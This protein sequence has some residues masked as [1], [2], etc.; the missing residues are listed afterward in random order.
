MKHFGEANCVGGLHT[1]IG[2]EGNINVDDK[3]FVEFRTDKATVLTV[4][5]GPK[6]YLLEI[7]DASQIILSSDDLP[8]NNYHKK[9]NELGQGDKQFLA[10]CS[11]EQLPQHVCHL[12]RQLIRSIRDYSDDVLIEGK[13]R[14]WY[15]KPKNFVAVTIQNKKMRLCIQVKD[16]PVL[17]QLKNVEVYRDKR[18][19]RLF[20][21]QPFQIDDVLKAVR[22]SY[23]QCT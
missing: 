10:S 19:V 23:S 13:N 4:G 2:V 12:A 1:V 17:D 6:V 21:E 16:S 9:V 3:G 14:K 8:F 11:Y 20:L 22:A 5:S 15:T 7:G 18:Y